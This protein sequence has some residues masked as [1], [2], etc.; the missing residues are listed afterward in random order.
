MQPLAN[1]HLS[2]SAAIAFPL[3][4]VKNVHDNERP[5][6]GILHTNHVKPAADDFMEF[7]P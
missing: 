5:L 2:E 3:Q 4:I 6:P 1:L 7:R